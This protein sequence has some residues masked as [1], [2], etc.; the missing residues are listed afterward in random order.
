MIVICLHSVE[1][2][3]PPTLPNHLMSTTLSHPHSCVF[4]LHA[5]TI[6]QLCVVVTVKVHVHTLTHTQ[7]RH[8]RP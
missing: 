6:M 3:I 5:R 7:Y 1:L 4:T 2:I 8:P